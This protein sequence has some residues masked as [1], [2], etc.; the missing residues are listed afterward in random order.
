MTDEMP[1]ESDAA[2][3][4]SSH[5]PAK[6]AVASGSLLRL[7]DV[8]ALNRSF[9]RLAEVQEAL[10]DRL[11]ALESEHRSVWQRSLP[12]LASGVLALAAIALVLVLQP[13]PE[14]VTVSPPE[15]VVELPPD[16]AL[17][18]AIRQMTAQLAAQMTAMEESNAAHQ[19]ERARL[20][21]Q[22]LAS[23]Q[24]RI[25]LLNTI[26][27]AQATSASASGDAAV[28]PAIE[29]KIRLATPDGVDTPNL[30]VAEVSEEEVWI[31][32]TN[33]LLRVDGFRD[34]RFQQATRVPGEPLLKDVV[35]M[36]WGSNGMVQAVIDAAEVHFSLHQMTGMLVIEFF[37]GW[38]AQGGSR[39]P[40]PAGGLR[41]DLDGVDVDAWLVHLPSLEVLESQNGAADKAA[42]EAVRLAIDALI[43]QKGSFR[44]YRMSSLGAV[45]GKTLRM[46][47]I[48]WY[49]ND[50]TLL[51]TIEAD[52]MEVLL[53]DSGAVELQLHDGAFL[54]G[55]VKH[56]FSGD[57]FRLHLP[58]QDLDRW[59][60]SGIPCR[61]AKP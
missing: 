14:A 59:R 25:A 54:E 40:L 26:G 38:K 34:L 35:W 12:W 18:D 45:D 2:A 8:Q 15:V 28:V 7:R 30:G 13:K 51:K 46:V 37:D 19:R 33:A 55:L 9:R 4:P 16:P 32:V 24:N 43:S 27:V 56:P 42:A 17:A 39:T 44:Y 21:D 49:H 50:G 58:N 1:P 53:H 5:L 3:D 11:D 52:S 41:I 47:Q 31:G 29:Q 48:N 23:E 60:S 22:L 10:L 57:R 36:E 61:E 20:V 6:A